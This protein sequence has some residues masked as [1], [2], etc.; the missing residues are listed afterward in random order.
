MADIRRSPTVRAGAHSLAA[1]NA[2][3]KLRKSKLILLIDDLLFIVAA[4]P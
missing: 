4:Y 1:V 2:V 3:D